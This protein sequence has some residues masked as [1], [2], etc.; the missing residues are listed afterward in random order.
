VSPPI[1]A[2]N[3]YFYG[4]FLTSGD[5]ADE[6]DYLIDMQRLGAKALNSWGLVRGLQVTPA[7]VNFTVAAGLGID[8]LGRLVLLADA[9]TIAPPAGGGMLLTLTYAETRHTPIDGGPAY[10]VEGADLAWRPEAENDPGLNLVLGSFAPGGSPAFT[11][12]GRTY[13]GA[14]VGT[15]RFRDPARGAGSAITGWNAAEKVGLRVDAPLTTVSPLPGGDE[16]R[17]SVIGGPLGVGIMSPGATL[18]VLGANVARAGPGL[19]TSTGR[20]VTGTSPDL[21]AIIHVGAVLI[22]TDRQGAPKQS[23]VVQVLANGVLKTETPLDCEGA[24]FTF[25]Q[26]LLVSVRSDD[27]TTA[28]SIDRLARVGLG[29]EAPQSRLHVADGDLKLLGDG[30]TLAFAGDGSIATVAGDSRVALRASKARMEFHQQGDIQLLPGRGASPPVGLALTSAGDVGIGTLTPQAKLDVIGWIQ[31]QAGGF[32]FPDG[33]V[34]A[35]A[36]VSIPIGSIIDWWRGQANAQPPDAFRICDGGV[37]NDPAS[38]FDG[39][40]V[41]NLAD[42]FTVG[43]NPAQVGPAAA[44]EDMHHHAYSTPTHVHAFPHTHPSITNQET[45]SADRNDGMAGA[46]DNN[47]QKEHKHLFSA[48]IGPASEMNTGPNS[49]AN[50]DVDTQDAS[51]VPPFVGLLKLIRIK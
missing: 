46:P 37:V 11:P 8:G 45:G 49:D 31:S 42:Q 35:T 9:R 33:T 26:A 13:A 43:V 23:V 40:A 14:P 44:G 12:S 29:I 19:L 41:P 48:T 18:D 50:Q 21:A 1:P 25:Q 22:T 4:E 6:Q 10:I 34:Q 2:E 39:K 15:A 24:A 38:P 32:V 20:L 47:A 17:L 36:E 7:G 30:R 28:L 27:G 51:L 3:A 5:Y 16:A